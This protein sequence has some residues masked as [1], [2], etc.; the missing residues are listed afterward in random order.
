MSSILTG[1]GTILPQALNHNLFFQ[2]ATIHQNEY[3]D[4]ILIDFKEKQKKILN[5]SKKGLNKD[6][7]SNRFK[8]QKLTSR[9][10]DNQTRVNVTQKIRDNLPSLAKIKRR[11]N[12]GRKV[13]ITKDLNETED[14]TVNG[15]VIQNLVLNSTSLFGDQFRISNEN[16]QTPEF[17]RFSISIYPYTRS[18]IEI[19]HHRHK[20]I[21]IFENFL[22]QTW[23]YAT[24]E[25][26]DR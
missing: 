12:N 11:E 7:G 19:L 20:I 26:A 9:I 22:T 2:P 10:E 15:K 23:S 21:E 16:N 18:L 8:F 5:E 17:K 4:P 24:P 25:P 3:E 6:G 1:N 13:D 14:N